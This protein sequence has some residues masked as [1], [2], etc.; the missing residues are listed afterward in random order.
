VSFFIRGVAP[1]V[2]P[3]NGATPELTADDLRK[4][5]QLV[6]EL[7]CIEKSYF[8]DGVPA[9]NKS[10]LP[11]L[12]VDFANCSRRHDIDLNVYPFVSKE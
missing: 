5:K 1:G 11:I 9:L 12:G 8:S 10:P 4:I 2:P 3:P 6:I 7:T